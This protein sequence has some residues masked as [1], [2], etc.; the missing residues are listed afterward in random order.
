M[1]NHVFSLNITGFRLIIAP[2]EI[3]EDHILYI[4]KLFSNQKTIRLSK[5]DISDIINYNVLIIDGMGFLSS[6][7]QYCQL[8]YIGGGFGKGI[9]NILE[10]VTFGKPVVFGPNYK[11]FTEAVDLVKKGG[12]YSFHNETSLKTLIRNFVRLGSTYEKS[13]VVSKNFI[14]TNK[15]A[16]QKILQHIANYKL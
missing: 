8:A 5:A 12:A 10:A 15:G 6:L 11:K 16:T 9:H 2:H 14:E 13:V 4:E 7:Y 3:H 1:L